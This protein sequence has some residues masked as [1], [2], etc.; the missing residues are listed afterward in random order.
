MLRSLPPDQQ[1]KFLKS[2]TEAEAR[3]LVYLW[4]F[5]A[6]PDDQL[7]P[8]GQWRTW[9][10]LAGRG[11]GKTRTGAEWVRS[12]AE[13]AV[14]KRIALVAPTAGDTREVMVEG[15]SGILAI[16]RPDFRPRYEPSKRRLTWPNGVRATTFSAEEPDRLRGPQHD[17][18]WCDEVCFWRDPKAWSNL[19]FGLRLG[20]DPQV[21]VTTTPRPI[22]L[23]REIMAD[24]RTVKTGGSTYENRDNLAGPFLEQI[25]SKYEGTRLGLQELY[26]EVLEITEG[27]WFSG[28]SMAKHVKP[29]AAYVPGLP[30]WIAIDCGTSRHTGAVFFQVRPLDAYRSLVTVFADYYAVDLFSEANARAI[31]AKAEQ[32]C[33]GQIDKVR[34]DPASTAKT[35]VGPAAFGEYQRVFGPRRT[36]YWPM[37]LVADGLDQIEVLMGGPERESDLLI[38]PDCQHTIDAFKNYQRAEGP[39]GV[40]LDHPK[41]PQHPHE[42]LMDS[43]RGG[44]RDA[45]PEGR[46]PAPKFHARV[47][48]SRVF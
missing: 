18:A 31:L 45:F 35:G 1:A 47:H 4:E 15:E 39:G 17:A 38:H 27:A 30:V 33:G 29:E 43:L 44:L 11:F 9:L 48:P 19:M 8:S 46:R 14:A 16:S 22:P 25:V 20:R 7:A 21:C 10:V 5:W 24:P 36:A 28:F 37:H 23:L 6:R 26:A 12:L 3:E 42:E 2:L 13:R 34:L 41:D 32:V 40:W